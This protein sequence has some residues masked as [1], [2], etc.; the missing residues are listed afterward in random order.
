MFKKHMRLTLTLQVLD[1][2]TIGATNFAKTP[3]GM[4]EGGREE[5]RKEPEWERRVQNRLA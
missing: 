5:G 2:K 1:G 3:W 4:W